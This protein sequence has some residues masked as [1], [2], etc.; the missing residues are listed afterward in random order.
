LEETRKHSSEISLQDNSDIFLT[1]LS[2]SDI[3]S[4]LLPY[5]YDIYFNRH[6]CRRFCNI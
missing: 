3:F 2:L 5:F 1:I 6:T 4:Y